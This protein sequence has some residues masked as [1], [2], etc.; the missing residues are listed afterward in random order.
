MWQ[1]RGSAWIAMGERDRYNN[2]RQLFLC[3]CIQQLLIAFSSL[4]NV[5]IAILYERIIIS[6]VMGRENAAPCRIGG[7]RRWSAHA[8]AYILCRWNRTF[9]YIVSAHLLMVY[10]FSFPFACSTK[11]RGGQGRKGRGQVRKGK[12][13][14]TKGN[15]RNVSDSQNYFTSYGED[16]L[17]VIGYQGWGFTLMLP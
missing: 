14:K 7:M 10:L 4:Y 12:V 13:G 9:S 17:V 15:R 11:E 3:F 6:H 2:K 1:H 5:H 8:Q 16:L